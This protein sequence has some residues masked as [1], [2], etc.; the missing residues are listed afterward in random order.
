M[1]KN[2]FFS[3]ITLGLF[4][5][6]LCSIRTYGQNSVEIS[7]LSILIPNSEPSTKNGD[8]IWMRGIWHYI[9]I[10]TSGETADLSIVFYYGDT[11]QN[12]EDRNETNYY[13]WEYDK[14]NWRDLQHNSSYIELEKCVH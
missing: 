4:A 11:P 5:I 10:T 13:E 12:I 6:S 2:R 14:G 1:Q 8:P 7:D 9:N 3:L